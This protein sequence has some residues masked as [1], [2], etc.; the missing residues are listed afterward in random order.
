MTP[1]YRF[2]TKE[3][4]MKKLLMLPLILLA[5]SASANIA[6][7]KSDV[8][9]NITA[10]KE[11]VVQEDGK[12]VLKR[13]KIDTAMPGDVLIYTLDYVNKGD[14]VAT[15]V[16]LNDPV[17]DGTIYIDGSA[18]G[19]GS[20]ITFSID[21]GESFNSPSLLIYEIEQAGKKVSRLASPDLYTHI[22]WQGEQVEAG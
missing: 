8:K 16:V 10:E 4:K 11:I 22:R 14:E 6:S 2:G 7:A 3:K 12:D 17:P 18:F 19:P 21:G 1:D 20:D 13:V 9:I 5:L 15:D